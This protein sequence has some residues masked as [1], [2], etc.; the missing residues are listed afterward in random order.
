[1]H[2][3]PGW[4][5]AGI[6]LSDFTGPHNSIEDIVRDFRFTEYTIVNINDFIKKYPDHD[7]RFGNEN[8]YNYLPGPSHTIYR[9]DLQD[10]WKINLTNRVTILI[11]NPF[12]PDPE[13]NIIYAEEGEHTYIAFLGNYFPL[14]SQNSESTRQGQ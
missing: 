12:I 9:E 8:L 13:D 3:Q 2:N 10:D 4:Y 1:M 7:F 11:D 14:L 5:T 6:N